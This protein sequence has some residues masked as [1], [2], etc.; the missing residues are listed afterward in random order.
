MRERMHELNGTLQVKSDAFGTSMRAT[1]PLH[2]M[3][4]SVSL[5]AQGMFAQL[6]EPG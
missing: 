5:G 2:A 4:H 1:V 3:Q 6:P